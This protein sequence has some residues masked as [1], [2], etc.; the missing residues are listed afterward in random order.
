MKNIVGK[1]GIVGALTVC[2]VMLGGVVRSAQQLGPST[3]QSPYVLPSL[4]VV[5]TASLLSVND[6]PGGYR[7]VG[8]PDGLGAFDNGDGTFTVL[9]N[10]ELGNTNGVMR[11]HGGRGAFV[12]KWIVDRETLA[13]TS[14]SDLIERV[15]LWNATTQRS[16]LFTTP[17]SFN[18]FCSADLPEPTAFFNPASGLGSRERIFMNGEEGGATGY[19]VATV[20]TGADAGNAYALGKFNLATNG[21]GINAV[22]ASEN[23]LASPFPQ[24]KTIVITNHDGGTGIMGNAVAVYV[25]TKQASG[26]EV[27]KAGLMNGTLKF[28]NVAGNP[29]EIVD[30]TTRATNITNGARFTLSGTTS[31]VFSRPED[32][33]WNPLNPREYYFVTTDRLDQVAD[34]VG[35]QI[36]QTRLWRLTFDDIRNPDLGGKIDLLINGRSVGS[37]KVNMFDNIT[38]NENSGVIVLVEDVGNAAHNGKVWVYDPSTDQLT[39]V[40]NHDPARFGGI[41]MAA[42]APFNQD[43][44]ASGVLDVSSILGAGRYLYV[45]QAH[46][47]P[48]ANTA[49]VVEGGQLQIARIPF[50]VAE[51]KDRCKGSGWGDLFRAN[52][53]AFK[54]Q[55]DCVQYVN[56][57]K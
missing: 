15:F 51:E 45:T 10:H 8:I 25:G 46:Y 5:G 24:D 6:T 36:G 16:D 56:T 22:G 13:V 42:T 52:G 1:T 31:T 20:V 43:E 48:A 18:R 38:V 17:F 57:G 11:R 28:V 40:A 14:G 23:S 54:N 19:Q 35:T 4:P 27:E 30:N 21:S 39:R 7:M 2:A 37:D 34:G 26:N 9:M 3:L 44:E 50:P 32:G 53:T 29:T 12:S 49:E 55:G 33:A 41:G 47:A